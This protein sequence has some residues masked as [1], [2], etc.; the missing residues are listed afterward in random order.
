MN[1]PRQSRMILDFDAITRVE[2]LGRSPI[3]E[4]AVSYDYWVSWWK[5]HNR[6]TRGKPCK[7]QC[8]TSL[9]QT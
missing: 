1:S 3:G 6:L 7:M 8:C 9:L 5:A 4:Y 2:Q